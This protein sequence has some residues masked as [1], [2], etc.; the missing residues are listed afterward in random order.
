MVEL[1]MLNVNNEDLDGDTS[2]ETG[3]LREVE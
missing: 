1:P 3:G 2:S